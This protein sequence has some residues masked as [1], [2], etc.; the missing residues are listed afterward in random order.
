MGNALTV[1]ERALLKDSR[2]TETDARRLKRLL[3]QVKR[4]SASSASSSSALSSSANNGRGSLAED[5]RAAGGGGGGSAVARDEE[6]GLA[7]FQELFALCVSSTPAPYS[8]TPSSSSSS[9]SLDSG[10]ASSLDPPGRLRVLDLE[11]I[12]RSVDRDGSGRVSFAELVVWLG[13]Y[14]RGSEADKLRHLFES[15]DL[16]G[17]GELDADELMGVLEILRLSF[18]D[19]GVRE[20]ESIVRAVALV[21]QLDGGAGGRVSLEQWLHIGAQ[22]GLVRELLG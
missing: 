16:D 7:E 11:Q 15:F 9:L 22:T 10:L 21:R 5:S 12:F 3:A 8:T 4:T 20:A 14:Q 19:R 18:A 2:F 6:I 17:N 1:E 13:V